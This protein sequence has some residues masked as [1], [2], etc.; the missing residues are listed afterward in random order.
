MTTQS[1]DLAQAKSVLY[2]HSEGATSLDLDIVCL[3]LH[4]LSVRLAV[5]GPTGRESVLGG[6]ELEGQVENFKF[7]PV[8]MPDNPY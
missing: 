8:D 1:A 3:L 4:Q 5:D 2:L 7:Q 6:E